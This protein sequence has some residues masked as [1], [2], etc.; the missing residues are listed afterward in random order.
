MLTLGL[1]A[2]Y[3]AAIYL[4]IR[5]NLR[6]L[7]Q[8]VLHAAQRIYGAPEFG[9]YA[10]AAGIKQILSSAHTEAS[11]HFPIIQPGAQFVLL[12]SGSMRKLREAL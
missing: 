12:T 1:D 4:G 7:T 11:D 6:L 8:H 5:A 9:F 10:P 3:C 2:A